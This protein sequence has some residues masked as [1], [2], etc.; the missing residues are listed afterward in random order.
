M[1]NC[2]V[3]DRFKC[4][5]KLTVCYVPT[6]NIFKWQEIKFESNVVYVQ[7]LYKGSTVNK[8]CISDKLTITSAQW[9]YNALT[10]SIISGLAFTLTVTDA[11][12]LVYICLSS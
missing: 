12:Q 11:G 9:R 10:L 7:W 5:H 2:R 6:L 3:L 4:A 8:T 1:C